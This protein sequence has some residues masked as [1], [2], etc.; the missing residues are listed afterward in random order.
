MNLFLIGYRG[1]GKSTIGREVARIL[2]KEFVDLDE[3]IV[4]NTGKKIPDLFASEG[5]EA[6]RKYETEALE[7]FAGK[8]AIVACGG[9]I[10]VKERNI[11]IL[12]KEGTVCLLKVD[13]RTSFERIYKDNNRPALTDK[14]PF[15]EIKFM[16]AKRHDAYE[17][18]KDFEVDCN[19]K[20]V[21]QC[22]AEV[23][24]KAKSFKKS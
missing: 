7:Q 1:T 18:A 10:I 19:N 14:D 5:E 20:D 3:V 22:A 16:L 11:Q 15:E 8:E 6:F 13:A 21:S 24:T 23:I 17:K 4:K 2:G 12:K 9:G